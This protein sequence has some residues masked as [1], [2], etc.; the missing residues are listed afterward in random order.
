MKIVRHTDADFESTIATLE[1][2]GETVPQ[3]VMEAVFEIVGQVRRRGDEAVAEYTLKFD[4]LDLKQSGM[5]LGLDELERA[6]EEIPAQDRKIL[7]VAADSIREFHERQL[8]DTWTYEPSPGITLGQKVTPLFRVGIYVPGGTAAYPSSVLMNA[9]P[10]K[11]AGVRE[12]IMVVPTPGGEVNKTVLAAAA[13]CG[14]DRVFTIGGAQAVAAL[15]YGT[16]TV[17]RVDKIVGP[18]NIYVAMAKKV[19]FGDV[20]I[21]M[22]AGPSEILVLADST[23]D[24]VLAAADLLSQAEHD[25]LAYPIFVTDDEDMLNRTVEEIRRQLEL[26]P[27]QD[28]A[29][30]SL[31]SRGYLLLAG[32]MEQAI[33]VVNRVAIEHLELMVTDPEKTLDSIENAGAIFLGMY[34]AEALGDYMAGPNHVLPTGGT[35]RFFSPLGVYDF[36]KRSSIIWYDREAFLEKAGMVAQFA[37]LEGLEAHARAVDLRVGKQ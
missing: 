20:D 21:D 1:T 28:I 26:L 2:R 3:G 37:R 10:A 18:G 6:L 23:A 19:V 29:R 15:A 7:E 25:P 34:T 24:P 31:D 27:R 5:E 4:N 12:V 16:S 32:N 30:Q 8:E 11:V 9:I 35:A 33:S 14:V 36:I 17:P 13:I 22:I